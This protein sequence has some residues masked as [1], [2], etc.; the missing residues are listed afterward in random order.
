MKNVVF[1]ALLLLLLIIPTKCFSWG[2]DGHR[3]MARITNQ[4]LSSSIKDSL[5]VYLGSL[6]LEDCS[7]WMDEVRSDH[8]FDYLKPCHYINIEKGKDFNANTEEN[9]I[10]KLNKVIERLK[11]RKLYS[12]DEVVVD[13]KILIH[14]IGDLHQP[15]HVGYGV[16]KGGNTINVQFLGKESNLHRVWDSEIINK[17]NITVDTC[18]LWLSEYSKIKSMKSDILGWMN[19]GRSYLEQIYDI[20]NDTIDQTYI[21]KNK[22]LIEK[23]LLKSGLR[24]CVL[25]DEIFS[26]SGK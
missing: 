21:R 5:A 22:D 19:E 16:D 7:V 8:N 26:T 10:N 4:N 13:I 17:E 18:N 14:L 6:N 9:I 1:S 15:L 12:K 20:Q 2:G 24:L 11:H 3:I 25:L 23:Q